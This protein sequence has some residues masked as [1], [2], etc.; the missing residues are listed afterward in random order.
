MINPSVLLEKAKFDVCHLERAFHE[1]EIA[2]DWFTRKDFSAWG[3]RFENYR[4]ITLLEAAVKIIEVQSNA[5]SYIR[6]KDDLFEK[7]GTMDWDSVQGMSRE[8]Q[9]KV[10]EIL[11]GVKWA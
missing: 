11:E 3:A 5:I 1:E 6:E 2:P 8:A 7:N 9:A 10:Q 4:L